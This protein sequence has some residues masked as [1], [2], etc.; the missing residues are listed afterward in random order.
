MYEYASGLAERGH[1]VTVV[2]PRWT[3]ASRPQPRA[4]LRWAS[5]AWRS[6]RA[7]H[8]SIR[9]PRISWHEISP[10]VRLV[11]LRHEPSEGDIP[12]GDAIIASFW[13]S[14]PHVAEYPATKGVK[15]QYVGGYEAWAGADEQTRSRMAHAYNLPLTKLAMSRACAAMV[16]ECDGTDSPIHVLPLALDHAVYRV[17]NPIRNRQEPSIA[18]AYRSLPYKGATDGLEAARLAKEKIP[19]LH[20]TL[21]GS[22]AL[23]HTLEPWMEYR[24]RPTNADIVSIYNTASVFVVSSWAEGWGLP[25]ME[26]MACGSALCSTDTGGVYEYAI[27]QETALIS[28]PRQPGEL[29]ENIVRLLT[30]DQL[31]VRIATAGAES[32][33]SFT[34]DRAVDEFEHHIRRYVEQATCQRAA[35]AQ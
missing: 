14:A 6:L 10:K 23:E 28:P 29:A 35:I 17:T 2:H 24:H 26:A 3:W 32:V 22:N 30:D 19:N 13:M 18:M 34:W 7:W 31:R 21:F 5:Q 4:N 20:L 9:P 1:S 11:F 27:H 33:R 8:E 12:D 25:G 15:L 16:E